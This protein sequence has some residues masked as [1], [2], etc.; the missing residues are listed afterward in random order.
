MMLQMPRF[1]RSIEQS[2][3]KS[4]GKRA[5]TGSGTAH[6]NDIR[7][8]LIRT[9]DS[10]ESKQTLQDVLLT[11]LSSYK[12]SRRVETYTMQNESESGQKAESTS[13]I[14]TRMP[15]IFNN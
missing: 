8:D 3:K 4:A 7:N 15:L 14:V 2:T 13:L 6:G 1:V 10:D 12:G 11:P 5:K 9:D